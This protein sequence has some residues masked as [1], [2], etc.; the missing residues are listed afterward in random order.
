MAGTPFK[1]KGN[2]FKRNFGTYEEQ[3]AAAIEAYESGK[4]RASK[5]LQMA[6]EDYDSGYKEGVRNVHHP[7][8]V[9]SRNIAKTTTKKKKWYK[10]KP[11]GKRNKKTW[12]NPFD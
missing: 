9:K 4:L 12:W 6:Q 5:A 1:M 3:R 2:P 11:K 10:R 8:G 7:E